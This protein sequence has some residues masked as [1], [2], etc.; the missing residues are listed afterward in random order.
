MVKT[1]TSIFC[2]RMKVD[3]QHLMNL[4]HLLESWNQSEDDFD[5]LMLEAGQDVIERIDC[6]L[7]DCM[8]LST[9][10]WSVLFNAQKALIEA[11]REALAE[12][13]PEAKPEANAEDFP[14]AGDDTDMLE[15][16]AVTGCKD[17][18]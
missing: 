1:K 7:R 6:T 3:V 14:P 10:E 8:S 9:S 12:A 18:E 5:E 4:L 11:K 15:D 16:F 13:K 17:G 2:Q